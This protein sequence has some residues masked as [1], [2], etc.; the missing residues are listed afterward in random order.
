MLTLTGARGG[1]AQAA[2]GPGSNSRVN[3]IG[4]F[5]GVVGMK[6]WRPPLNPEYHYQDMEKKWGNAVR[7]DVFHEIRDVLLKPPPENAIEI[8]KECAYRLEDPLTVHAYKVLMPFFDTVW[9]AF[10]IPRPEFLPK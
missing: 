3:V 4:G 5:S 9:G 2:A 6:M 1:S 7:D 8:P 10:Q